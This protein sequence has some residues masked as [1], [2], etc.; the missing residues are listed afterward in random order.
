[1]RTTISLDDR[2]LEAVK[3]RAAAE[4]RSVSAFIAGVLDDAIKRAPVIEAERPFRL[5]VVG[6][7]GPYSG[8]DLDRP[9][10]LM[11]A[12]DEERYG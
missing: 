12:E 7:G 6:G 8:V 5:V 11:V 2:I 3:Q 10:E 9:R 1:M 4:G